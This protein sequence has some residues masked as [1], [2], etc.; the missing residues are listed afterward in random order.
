MSMKKMGKV[1]GDA[2]R[3]GARQGGRAAAK[4]A[5]IGLKKAA[6]KAPDF[7][8][9][10]KWLIRV[11][12]R[13]PQ[14]LQLYVSLLIDNRVS[15][16]VKVLLV[17][18]IAVLGAQF[19]LTGP[20]AVMQKLLSW[21]FGPFAL[22]PSIFILLVTL[23]MCYHMLGSSILEEYQK[24]IFGEKDSVEADLRRVRKALG[25]VWNKLRAGYKKKTEAAEAALE[26]A[27]L[28]KDGEIN[29]EKL[30]EAVDQVVEIQTSENLQ[31][32]IDRS[33]KRLQEAPQHA[34]AVLQ[35]VRK[36]LPAHTE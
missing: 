20:L 10:S 9:F 34:K 21:V 29:D 33:V 35:A 1:V 25:S 18:G 13:L 14:Y 11:V 24:K 15:H 3:K 23:D 16:K 8:S 26:Q 22:L 2:L 19:A 17:T 28:I 4:G 32:Q 7:E 5:A 36:R 27:G 6:E 12:T 31:T 30:Q